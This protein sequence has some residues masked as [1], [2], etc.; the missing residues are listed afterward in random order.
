M[1]YVIFDRNL[2]FLSVYQDKEGHIAMDFDYK[3][4]EQEPVPGSIMPDKEL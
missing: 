3:P 1:C 2:M 4:P